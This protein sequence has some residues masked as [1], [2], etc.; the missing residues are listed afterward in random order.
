MARDHGPALLA[1]ALAAAERG[2][3]VFPLRPDTDLP[4]GHT[5][6]RCPRNG[7][8]A[9]GHLTPD[10][11]ATTELELI[12]Q[13]WQHAPYGV[14]I[15][16]GPSHLVVIVLDVPADPRDVPPKRWARPGVR[17]G[18]DVFAVV[19]EEAGQHW[20][21]TTYSA[22]TDRGTFHLYFAAPTQPP[23]QSR[24]GA[25]GWKTA[26]RADGGYVPAAGTVIEGQLVRVVHDGAPAPLPAW[27]AHR[28]TPP[29]AAARPAGHPDD[30]G[31]KV[32]TSGTPAADWTCR[33][34]H[35]EHVRGRAA[36]ADLVGRA[37]TGSCPHQQPTAK[38]AAA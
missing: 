23:I 31:L 17:D 11:R 8:C 3:R 27:L 9:G 29:S 28:L 5:A 6:N 13:C 21:T 37:R 32:R 34:G 16:T 19:C 33:C 22:R 12:R 15:A 18:L 1:A 2:W 7:R 25:L 35:Q 26:V 38:E 4:A 36:V 14:G 24:L 20:P 30:P 10:H